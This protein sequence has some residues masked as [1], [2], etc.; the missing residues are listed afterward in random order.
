MIFKDLHI[1]IITRF[2]III[3]V[4]RRQ[5]RLNM[6]IPSP[7][8]DY[9]RFRLNKLNTPEFEHLK[10]LFFWPVFGFLFLFLE[11]ILPT[12]TKVHYTSVSCSLDKHIPFCEFFVIP[13]L[14]WFVFLIGMLLY[15]LFYDIN[16]FK[17][18]MVYVMVSY[19]LTIIIYFIYPTKQ[20]LRPMIDGLERNNIF[21]M[22]MDHYYSFDTNT[23]VCPSLHVIGSMAVLSASLNMKR[24]S[25]FGWRT[26]YI[27]AAV[28][29]SIST[30]FLKQHSAVD[31][32]AALPICGFAHIAAFGRSSPL[33]SKRAEKEKVLTKN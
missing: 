1:I 17:K 3:S 2:N 18:M 15:T 11:R 16:A 23:N 5:I 25:S 26:Y 8:V 28:L 7:Q 9:R 33:F 29:I 30:V 4:A 6:K 32:F 13:Y 12:L 22:I 19:T 31:I 14:W 24:F 27:V 20:E 21:T 10:L